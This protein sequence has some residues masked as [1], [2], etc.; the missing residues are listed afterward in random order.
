M[1]RL[2]YLLL[3][4]V[5]E[6]SSTMKSLGSKRWDMCDLEQRHNCTTTILLPQRN[7]NLRPW[8]GKECYRQYYIRE[9]LPG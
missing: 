4:P 8:V 1:L 9:N 7:T 5:D 3:P 6:S 2:Q